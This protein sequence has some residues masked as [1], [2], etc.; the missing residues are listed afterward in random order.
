MSEVRYVRRVVSRYVNRVA[1]SATIDM[2]SPATTAAK[3][4][5][6]LTPLLADEPQEVFCA[7]LLNAKHR[8]IGYAEISRG[9]L[10]T[11]LVHPREVFR[12][13][14]QMNAASVIVAHNHPSG[15]PEPSAED[16]AATQRLVA[17]GNLLGIPVLDHVIIA[18]LGGFV[19]LRES[20]AC[21]KESSRW[22][23]KDA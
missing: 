11:S 21:F 22:G 20:E 14:I 6:I 18:P 10:T 15:D 23:Q 2:G 9:T 13:A 4:A 5:S 8:V 1:E 16:R 7:L 19:S 17:A 3:V 12:A